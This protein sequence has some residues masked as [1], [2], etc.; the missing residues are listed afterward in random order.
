[1]FATLPWHLQALII[2]FDC[3]TFLMT[4]RQGPPNTPEEPD[5]RRQTTHP[6]QQQDAVHRE[7]RPGTGKGA[8]ASAGRRA[9]PHGRLRAPPGPRPRRRPPRRSSPTRHVPRQQQQDEGKEDILSSAT[10]PSTAQCSKDVTTHQHHALPHPPTPVQGPARFA[11]RTHT[12]VF[13]RRWL[14][15]STPNLIGC[16]SQHRGRPGFTV[17]WGKTPG[18]RLVGPPS[19]DR[20]TCA[21]SA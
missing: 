3:V 6:P 8:T 16:P 20:T 15:R 5:C 18:P 4:Q 9:A 7:L 1:M 17:F 2:G 12:G 14:C 11:S 19:R 10:G 21:R 13:S